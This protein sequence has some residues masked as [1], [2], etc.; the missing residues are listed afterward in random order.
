VLGSK[1]EQIEK[2]ALPTANRVLGDA[3]EANRRVAAFEL[4]LV[5][6]ARRKPYRSSAKGQATIDRYCVWLWRRESVP[7]RMRMSG[8]PP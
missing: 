4:M 6:T 3:F 2:G 8:M 7:M 1:P 5:P